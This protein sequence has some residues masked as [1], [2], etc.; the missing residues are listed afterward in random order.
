M[1]PLAKLVSLG[2]SVT[3]TRW[4]RAD[5][6]PA[7]R[8]IV[9]DHARDTDTLFTCPPSELSARLTIASMSHMKNIEIY[10]VVAGKRFQGGKVLKTF[11]SATSNKCGGP[12]T[13][14]L[15]AAQRLCDKGIECHARK[16]HS[17]LHGA[18]ESV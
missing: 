2:C 16:Y 1:D 3:I 6:A 9:E 12:A 8:V 4:K 5:D 7:I 18:L 15:R 17:D 10:Q 11:T 14:A 13:A